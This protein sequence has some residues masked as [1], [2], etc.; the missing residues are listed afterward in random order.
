MQFLQ[1]I[2]VQSPRY[3]VSG[4]MELRISLSLDAGGNHTRDSHSWLLRS[5]QSLLLPPLV[6]HYGSQCMS[7]GSHVKA[8]EEDLSLGLSLPDT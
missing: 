3:G 8:L 2:Q 6:F 5:L 4:L 7:Y 1:R